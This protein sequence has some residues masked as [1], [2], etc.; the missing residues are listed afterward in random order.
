MNS[1][2]KG[3]E[4]LDEEK[5]TQEVIKKDNVPHFLPTFRILSRLYPLPIIL[6]VVIS[7]I[8]AYL[9]AYYF[10]LAGFTPDAG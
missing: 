8:L 3:V 7:G 5:S 9:T 2:D 4:P 10:F 6:V 1:E